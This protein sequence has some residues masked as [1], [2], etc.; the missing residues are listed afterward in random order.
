MVLNQ[1]KILIVDDEKA[2]RLGLSR[3]LQNAGFETLV[4]ECGAE[5]LCLM[6]LHQPA[7]IILDV[8]MRGLSGLEVCRTLRKKPETS[9][10]KIVFLS[11]KG[12]LRDKVEGL[13]AGGD[14]YITKP[15]DYRELIT[16]IKELL[17][18]VE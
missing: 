10:V 2:L 4:A 12:Q 1:N 5:A 8:M 17:E 9:A 7:L 18:A 14:Y 6:D 16:I 15:F 11:A 13:E 3:C